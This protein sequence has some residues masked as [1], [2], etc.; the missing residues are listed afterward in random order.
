MIA[1]GYIFL[2]KDHKILLGRRCNT[3]FEDGNYGL[4]AGHIEE[5]E[6]LTAGTVR[7]IKEEIGL[8]VQPED[9]RL[10]HVMHRIGDDERMDFF[11]V[12]DKW[13]GEPQNTEPEKCDD[14]SWFDL[15]RLPSN[16]IPYV[17]TALQNYL[18]GQLYSEFGW[19]NRTG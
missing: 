4:P 5:F 17:A 19:D 15:D 14:L 8:D 9:L 7:E 3:G 10:V 11:F 6:P 1:S 13:T 12:A 16:M 18:Q 2:I